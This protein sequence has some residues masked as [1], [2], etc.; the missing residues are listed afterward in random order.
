MSHYSEVAELFIMA[1][2]EKYSW[3]IVIISFFVVSREKLQ[4][5]TEHRL[6]YTHELPH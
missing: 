6:R 3:R 1:F 4:E 2:L 5:G